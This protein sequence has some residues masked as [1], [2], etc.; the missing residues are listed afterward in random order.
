MLE[1]WPFIAE[2]AV[3]GGLVGF[4]IGYLRARAVW[5]PKSLF[6]QQAVADAYRGGFRDGLTRQAEI[7]SEP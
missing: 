2:A 1:V 4:A 6:L 5:Q 7:R 3:A